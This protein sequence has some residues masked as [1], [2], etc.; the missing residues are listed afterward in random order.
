MDFKSANRCKRI[1]LNGRAP[2]RRLLH[3]CCRFGLGV[4]RRAPF[5]SPATDLGALLALG[6]GQLAL[7]AGPSGSGK[8][9]LLRAL[10]AALRAGPETV[11]LRDLFAKI[12]SDRAVIDLMPLKLESALRVLAAT[13]LADPFVL[14][15][16]P[17][18][19]SVGEQARFVLARTLA[20]RR[21]RRGWLLLDEFLTTLDRGSAL[22]TA[23]SFRR[24][25]SEIAPD[26]RIVVASP[27]DDLV[28][29]LRPDLVVRV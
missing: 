19:L 13:G 28:E 21:A 24:A 8:S 23:R 9:R 11:T 20:Q 27:Q 3:A 16:K 17:R 10:A 15:R 18:E 12:R 2:T 1:G 29:A 5:D 7:V 26:L 14:G 4:T 25:A 22:A 6:A